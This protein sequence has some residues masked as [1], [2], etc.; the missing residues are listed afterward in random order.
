[1]RSIA[2]R[3]ALVDLFIKIMPFLKISQKNQELSKLPTTT[4]PGTVPFKKSPFYFR[5][6]S[7]NKVRPC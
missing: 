1:M 2:G 5:R 3:P 6:N 7:P 4:F